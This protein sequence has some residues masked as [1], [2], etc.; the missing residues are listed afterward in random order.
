MEPQKA[1]RCLLRRQRQQWINEMPPELA[2]LLRSSSERLS[3]EG[4]EEDFTRA[5]H[6]INYVLGEK[7]RNA[8][9]DRQRQAEQHQALMQVVRDALE[10]ADA[11]CRTFKEQMTGMLENPRAMWKECAL[12][13]E[14]QAVN[15]L[16]CVNVGIPYDSPLISDLQAAVEEHSS[17]R[18]IERLEQAG[19]RQLEAMHYYKEIGAGP[20]DHYQL[21]AEA[22][23]RLAAMI[24]NGGLPS[25]AKLRK[26]QG[27]A[28]A[29]LRLVADAIG[30][31]RADVH[32]FWVPEPRQV[33]AAVGAG[34]C[35]KEEMYKWL[36]DAT[37]EQHEAAKICKELQLDEWKDFKDASD[38]NQETAMTL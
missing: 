9:E 12:Q 25:K 34:R 24:Q 13:C 17:E 4:G 19:L 11:S 29:N 36:G 21:A 8:G 16:R 5:V 35:T 20:A 32:R 28:L 18:M 26:A 27:K 22:N 31:S 3:P 30:V 6:V 2:E 23:F 10:P 7:D 1:L 33:Q 38:R 15:Y 14:E 37:N